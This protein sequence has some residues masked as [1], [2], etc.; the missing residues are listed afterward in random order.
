MPSKKL[1][2]GGDGGGCLRELTVWDTSNRR[3]RLAEKADP[4]QKAARLIPAAQ[5][6]AHGLSVR[7]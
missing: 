6:T 3:I 1:N 4:Q 5:N 7:D 2:V